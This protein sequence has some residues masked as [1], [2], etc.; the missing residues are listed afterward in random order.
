MTDLART[1]RTRLAWAAVCAAV[2][3]LRVILSLTTP[4]PEMGPDSLGYN[5][6]ARRLVATGEYAWVYAGDTVLD[7]AP[8]AMHLPGYTAFLAT[9]YALAD[10]DTPAQPLVSVIQALLS[11][12]TLYGIALLAERLSGVPAGWLALATAAVYP[13]FWLAYREVLTEDLYMLLCV[14]AAVALGAAL[15]RNATRPVLAFAVAGALVAAATYV[16]ALA[17]GWAALVAVILL[18]TQRDD[19]GRLLK[20]ILAAALVFVL[21]FIP[22]WVRN[23]RIYDTF[24]PFN[25]M[26]ASARLVPTLET[27]AE[28]DQVYTELSRGHLDPSEEVAHNDRIAQIA[29]E[30]LNAKLARDPLGHIWRR[31]RLFGISVLTYHPN[32]FGGFRG[33]GGVVELIHLSLL[34]LSAVGWRRYRRNPLALVLLALPVTLAL[35]HAPTLSFS[36]YF[37]PM[38]GFV[39]VMAGVGLRSI[40]VLEERAA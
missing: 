36:R 22:W 14:W 37:Y 4:A 29:S 2:A 20:G 38:M 31:V 9:L 35:V 30:R 10:G 12:L 11:G 24:V 15:H 1:Q 19:R 28:R 33:W 32:P 7:P 39:T 13:P 21:A 34:G 40:L 18:V 25:T 8:N 6:A 27:Q 26:T 3:A 5:D 16:R 17:L 23:A